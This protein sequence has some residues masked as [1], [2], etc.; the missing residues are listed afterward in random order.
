MQMKE[1]D[2]QKAMEYYTLALEH[3]FIECI[4]DKGYKIYIY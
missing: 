3:V 2:Y 1:G 4:L